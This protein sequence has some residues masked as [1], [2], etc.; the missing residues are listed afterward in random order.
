MT[1]VPAFIALLALAACGQPASPTSEPAPA[2]HAAA[3]AAAGESCQAQAT[4]TWNAGGA[5][6]RVEA[7][8]NGA[9]CQAAQATLVLRAPDARVLYT[10]SFPTAQIPLA[11]NP[12]GDEATLNS[13]LNAWID[14]VAPGAT[15]DALPAWPTGAQRPPG[16]TAQTPRATY[17]NARATRQPIYCFPDGGESNACVAVDSAGGTAVLLGS[18]TPERP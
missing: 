17:E 18:I 1:K 7:S 4:R 6:Y 5:A 12:N 8:A 11:F 15:A 16:F 9:T 14:N 13:D 2:E 3:P 10:A